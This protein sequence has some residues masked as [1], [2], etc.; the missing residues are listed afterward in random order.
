E[1]EN[2]RLREELQRSEKLK[3]VGTLAAG[4][5]HEIKNP[6]S[7]IKTF[8]EYLP[9]KH[10]DP[11]FRDKF[12]RIVGSEVEKINNI[13]GQVLDFAKPKPLSLKKTDMHVLLDDTLSLLSN[14]LLQK[15]I[16]VVKEYVSSKL[17][18]DVDPNQLKQAFL[19]IFLNAIDAMP[20]GGSL[21]IST[22]KKNNNIAISVQDTGCGIPKKNI[23]H[24]FDPFYSNK[25]GSTGL[26][27]SIVHGIIKK[28]NGSIVVE[29]GEGKGSKFIVKL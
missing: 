19:N 29:S 6:L 17:N 7:A 27:L 15:R 25:E 23:P 5:A 16:N 26:G 14:D 28:H 12:K 11:S 3:A 24:L 22:A 18:V 10:N 20:K 9:E 13:V 21:T 1:R 4:M 2:I 8:T